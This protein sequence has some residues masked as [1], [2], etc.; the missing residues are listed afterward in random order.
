[1]SFKSALGN[2]GNQINKNFDGLKSDSG[3]ND[4]K[5]QVSDP[6][7]PWKN[8]EA[9]TFFRPISITP[10]NWDRLFPYR[11]MVINTR[12]GNIVVNGTKQMD[13]KITRD[14]S[15][16]AIDFTPMT[17]QWIYTLPITPQQLAITDQYAI[18][19]TATL[20][21]IV[22]EHSG[23]R[24][25]MINA[26]GS[27]GV[28]PHR[29][30]IVTPPVDSSVG[31]IQSIFGGTIE[32]AG[33]ALSQVARTINSAT[34]THPATKPK[35]KRPENTAPGLNSTGYFY[36][37][38][39]QQFLEQYAEAKKNPS[40]AGWRLVFDIPKQN[41]S[42]VVTPMQFNWTQSAQKP[43]EI[44]YSLSMKAWRRIQLGVGF[45]DVKPTVQSL[46]PG[47]LQRILSTVSEARK[48]LS[49]LTNLIGAV[50]SDVIRPLEVLRQTSLFVKDYAG[51]VLTAADLPFQIQRDYKYAL[52]DFFK[53]LVVAGN[54]RNADTDPAVAQALKDM[55]IGWDRA[56]GT[57]ASGVRTGNLGAGAAQAQSIDPGLAIFDKP[58]KAHTLI[59]SANVFALKLTDT[60][61]ENVDAAVEA[62]RQITVDDLKQF[63]AV[64]NELSI[65]LANNFGAGDA[66]YNQIY[67]RPAPTTRIQEMTLDEYEILK[68]LYDVVQSYDIMTATTSID[69]A[70]KR[71]NM[72]YVA[73]LAEEAGMLFNNSESKIL[74]PVPFGA[75]IE[76]IAARYLGNA[77]RWLEVA[78]LNNLRSPY[79]D[80]NGFKYPLLSNA[81]GRQ[82]TV[83]SQENLY[84]GQ[85]IVL[86]SSTQP[87]TARK[88]LNLDR[89]S[90]TS[91]LLTLDGEA[92]LNN[93]TTTNAAYL[94]AYLPGTVNSQQKI[95]IPSE[96]PVSG[97][98]RI[99][100]P[101]SVQADP[102]VGL[103]KVDWLLT[104]T[105]DLAVNSFGDLRF[106]A[107]MTNLIQAL[108]IKIGTQKGR[109]LLH[110]EF[111]LGVKSGNM[112]SDTDAANVFDDINKL[113]SDDS[114]FDGLD[115]LQVL[116]NGPTM[117]INMGVRLAGNNGVF[118]IA[119]DVP[120]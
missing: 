40:N 11:L 32:A 15:R 115:S 99:T 3:E 95:F 93:F 17:N 112:V 91:F 83:G 55:K 107:G 117:T 48:T 69:D 21:G 56:E 65:Q 113:I 51:V 7:V 42:L 92:N 10:E 106:A 47:I 5:G 41:Q 119:F 90:D 96:V 57:S 71:T 44:T 118:P 46:S 78:T 1:M 98:A 16:S 72:E 120:T 28:W 114:R 74:V 12:E 101:A 36:A 26:Q 23:V 66:Y 104:D 64:I 39:L 25:K 53:S 88:I 9:S 19:T 50:R 2:L 108:R 111:G 24:F 89:L 85:R 54:L 110:P 34:S 30:S 76:A 61:K 8:S 35:S 103:S 81:S 102:L 6:I 100:V 67:G 70:N 13:I 87:Q 97:D 73:G 77:Q 14:P 43:M 63:R 86:G 75:S 31:I 45:V 94:R 27:M 59:D 116:I 20:L 29:G 33:S 79:I 80:E 60:Q 84:V 58:E 4:P 22:E 62:A 38:S 105:G 18:Q 52:S 109:V 49:S 37:L 82:V 68:V